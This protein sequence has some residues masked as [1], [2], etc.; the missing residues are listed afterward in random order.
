M[1]TIADQVQKSVASARGDWSRAMAIFLRSTRDLGV[2][3]KALE[4]AYVQAAEEWLA[5][6]LPADP[7]QWLAAR[8]IDVAG[9][10]RDAGGVR[11]LEVPW[12]PTGDSTLD[13]VRLIFLAAHPDVSP[14]MRAALTLRLVSGVP[15][16]DIA[17]MFGVSPSAM[18]SS[19]R[20]AKATISESRRQFPGDGKDFSM[21]LGEVLTVA[22]GLIAAAYRPPVDAHRLSMDPRFVVTALTTRL[23]ALFP[24]D[25]ETAAT[26][27]L[28]QLVDAW[29]EPAP[30]SGIE[31]LA[32]EDRSQWDRA[33][34]SRAHELVMQALTAGGRGRQVLR[35]SILS[36][37]SRPDAW[38]DV[39]WNEILQLHEVLVCV[40]PSPGAALSR[41]FALAQVEGVQAALSDL[42]H[43]ERT[44]SI[45]DSRYY[46]STKAELLH[47]AGREQEAQARRKQAER[48]PVTPYDWDLLSLRML[49]MP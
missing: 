10:L 42:S 18:T 29:G 35:A 41:I 25:P 7:A 48:Y 24:H 26:V 2:A 23:K 38:S 40:D 49:P 44:G 8:A 36:L 5:H 12:P 43:L 39:D 32:Q 46:F 3:G 20:R 21:Q 6:P 45:P 31:A 27:A 4:Q 37:F 33:A 14:F 16:E 30:G 9:T 15:V 47:M 19:L 17:A 28:A 13:E 22:S 1:T 11:S 34:I